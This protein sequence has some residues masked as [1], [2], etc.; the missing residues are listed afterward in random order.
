MSPNSFSLMH[1]NSLRTDK[2]QLLLRIVNVSQSKSSPVET[3]EG[4][5]HVI[6]QW[7]KEAEGL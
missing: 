7:G 5:R 6:N 3:E 4:S 2:T 1:M